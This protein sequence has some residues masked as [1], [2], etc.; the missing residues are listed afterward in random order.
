MIVGWVQGRTRHSAA[1]GFVPQPSLRLGRTWH[2]VYWRLRGETQPQR[3]ASSTTGD[4][5]V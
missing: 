3:R 2:P 5:G 4:P 1:L